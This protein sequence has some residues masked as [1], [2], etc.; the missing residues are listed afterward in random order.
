MINKVWAVYFSPTGGT[1]QNVTL[2]AEELGR[3]LGL[4]VST[5]DF[6][7]PDSRSEKHTF[8]AEDLVLLSV[9]TYAGRVPN[10]IL[11]DVDTLF[12][13]TQTPA[14]PISVF[15]NRSFD[16]ALME[17]T[18]LLEKHNFIPLAAAGI[19]HEHAFSSKV[20]TARPDAN[21][22]EE[23]KAF[24]KELAAK[25]T[26][27]NLT[28]VTEVK[29]HNPIGPYYTPLGTD[30]QPAKFLKAKP[31]TDEEKCTRCGECVSACP[32]GSIAA[33]CLTVTGPCIKCQACLKVC[34]I[35]AKYFDDAA[36]LSHVKM[37]ETNYCAK[38]PNYFKI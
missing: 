25:I 18:L 22:K 34:P 4:P 33:D 24:A 16:D 9:P 7:L 3:I 20:G 38:A 13:G 36:F 29:G 5:L 1:K 19:A 31:L 27:G 30:G 17:L 11:P 10:K 12:E 23:I 8:T 35:D 26:S 6:T 2:V 21:D 37:L 32:V 15:G 14:V 28:P